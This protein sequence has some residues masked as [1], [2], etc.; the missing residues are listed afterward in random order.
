MKPSTTK[1]IMSGAFGILALIAIGFLV[2]VVAIL[3]GIGYKMYL[4]EKEA[5]KP[6]R[7]T[8]SLIRAFSRHNQDTHSEKFLIQSK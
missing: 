5:R 7:R 3:I 6:K 4:L 1:T 2:A 8:Q